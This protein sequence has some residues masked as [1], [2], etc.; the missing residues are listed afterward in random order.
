[1]QDLYER[2]QAAL[3]RHRQQYELEHGVQDDKEFEIGLD[4]IDSS[5]KLQS[6]RQLPLESYHTSHKRRYEYEMASGIAKE[7]DDFFP[8]KMR[9][10]SRDD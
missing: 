8:L 3:A 7:T 4:V 5:P 10:V 2:R 1:M 6:E 9:L